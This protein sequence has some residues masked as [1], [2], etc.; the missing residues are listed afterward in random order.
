MEIGAGGCGGRE[1]K[2][3]SCDKPVPS[4]KYSEILYPILPPNPITK[5]MFIS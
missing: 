4:K 3:N 2:N 1:N 5:K